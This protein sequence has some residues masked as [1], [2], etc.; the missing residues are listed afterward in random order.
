VG[1]LEYSAMTDGEGNYE[2]KN[3]LP[4]SYRVYPTNEG[5]IF[6]P[7]FIQVALPAQSAQATNQVFEQV[8]SIRGRVILQTN[9]LAG[10]LLTLS[11]NAQTTAAVTTGTN[12]YYGFS[13]VLPGVYTV[14]PPSWGAGYNPVSNVVDL[15]QL[16]A[17]TNLIVFTANPPRVELKSYSS[18]N[19]VLSGVGL[20]ISNLTYLWQGSSNLSTWISL[21]N[22]V[23]PNAELLWNDTSPA[24]AQWF[25]RLSIPSVP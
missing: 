13:N 9:G 15:S 10:I 11:S 3:L 20:S 14:Q 2:F 18:T 7:S 24:P 23:S 6:M 21:T 5:M 4:G 1:E 12:G 16:N 8:F 22:Q 17:A 25:Y 19:R